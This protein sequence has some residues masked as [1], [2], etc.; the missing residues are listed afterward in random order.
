MQ[1][2]VFLIFGVTLAA[3][4]DFKNKTKE[5]IESLDSRLHRSGDKVC[6]FY[7]RPNNVVLNISLVLILGQELDYRT[8]RS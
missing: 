8:F 7:D 5:V 1:I 4:N 3:C 6:S 2:V